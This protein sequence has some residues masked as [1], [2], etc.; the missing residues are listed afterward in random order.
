MKIKDPL[1][2]SLIST[3]VR[4]R[5]SLVQ[6]EQ[7]NP[8]WEQIGEIE[9]YETMLSVARNLGWQALGWKIAG[10]NLNIQRKLRTNGTVFGRTFRQFH[11]MSPAHLNW[12]HLLDPLVESEFFFRMG[13]DL[14]PRKEPYRAAEVADAVEAVFI[15]IEVAECRFSR[16]HLPSQNLLVADGFASGRYVQGEEISNWQQVLAQPVQVTVH[17]NGEL[18]AS[19]SSEDVMAHPLHAVTW[20]ANRLSELGV[21]LQSKELVSSGSCTGMVRAR[22]HD[23]IEARFDSLG[24][25]AIHFA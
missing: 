9:G 7:Y 17:R 24:T 21:T 14:R 11:T 5:E 13:A 16:H 15:G 2:E 10:T 6:I 18:R 3:L 19:G 4:A 20:L 22:H 23:H 8:V 12:G 25:V 1:D